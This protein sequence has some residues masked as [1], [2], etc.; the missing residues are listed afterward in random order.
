MPDTQKPQSS[1]PP[2]KVRLWRKVRGVPA[3]E[4]MFF[5]QHLGVMLKAGI[6]LGAALNTLSDQTEHRYF[7]II[8]KDIAER[9]NQG[10][11]LAK[12]LGLYTNVFEEIF[13]NMIAAG[14][15]SG[16][17]EEVLDEL[18]KQMKKSHE[19][20]GK[21]RGAMIYPAI[22]VLAMVTIAILMMIFVVPKL[23]SIFDEVGVELPLATRILIAITKG[24]LSYGPLVVIAFVVMLVLL[25]ITFRQEK[26]KYLLH[27]L[28]LKLPIVS[29]I[30]KKIN[31]AHFARTLGSLL[32]TDIPIIESLVITSKVLK[33]RLYRK[34][35]SDSVE[36]V[37]KGQAMHTYFITKPKLFFPLVIQMVTVGEETGTL[38]N[39]L[40][41][42][43]DFFE[44]DVRQTMD[45]LPTI[46][47]PILIVLLGIAVAG[48]AVAFIMPLYSLTETI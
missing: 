34:A 37:K 16:K 10:Q 2:V 28:L 38:D 26:P 24:F 44:E 33:N 31:T 43:A 35:L 20:R 46:I 47:E 6:S 11:S 41:E 18:Y 13:V 19:L 22:I 39:I 5:V 3:T 14:E 17:Y 40:R 1:L 21:I 30:I 36:V 29:L 48:M 12:S 27:A 42:L 4:K 8:L 25:G 7:K 23:V 9:V 32:K 15:V 45:N